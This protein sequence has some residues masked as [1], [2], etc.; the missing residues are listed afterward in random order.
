MWLTFCWNR[1]NDPDRT[2]DMKGVR[3]SIISSHVIGY[4]GVTDMS[5]D[6]RHSAGNWPNGDVVE[7]SKS[8]CG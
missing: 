1:L 7:E 5:E 6:C 4:D 3:A 2:T 8:H